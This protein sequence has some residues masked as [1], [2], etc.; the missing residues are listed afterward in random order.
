MGRT[1]YAVG[2]GKD[3][4]VEGQTVAVGGDGRI[5]EDDLCDFVGDALIASRQEPN[6][7][8]PGVVTT[9][10][11]TGEHGVN[12][13]RGLLLQSIEPF[14]AAADGFYGS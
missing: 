5:C 11:S 2:L 3:F 8:I 6:R 1:S 12:H 7:P 9:Q 13:H 14:I 10:D 4:T